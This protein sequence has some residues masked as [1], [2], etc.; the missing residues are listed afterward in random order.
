[1]PLAEPFKFPVRGP[2]IESPVT[3]LRFRLTNQLRTQIPCCFP[4]Q[5]TPDSRS[6]EHPFNIACSA[7]TGSQFTDDQK[8]AA[9][10]WSAAYSF[11]LRFGDNFFPH[12]AC[13]PLAPPKA[14]RLF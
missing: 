12:P 8:P 14:H 5:L 2:E 9:S 4:E 6:P 3:S 1:M 11:A 7:F 10:P 13:H